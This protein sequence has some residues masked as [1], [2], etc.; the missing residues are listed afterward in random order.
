MLY[1]NQLIRRTCQRLCFFISSS[2]APFISSKQ[3]FEQQFAISILLYKFNES[4]KFIVVNQKLLPNGI[5]ETG[6]VGE[7]ASST[8]WASEKNSLAS[9]TFE[10]GLAASLR[11]GVLLFLCARRIYFLVE[12]V[13]F[14][15]GLVLVACQLI[16]EAQA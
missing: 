1:L 5:Q 7:Q 3:Q 10:V 8:L 11:G 4:T 14:L 12:E 9:E 2:R 6:V 16:R 13:E 15:N